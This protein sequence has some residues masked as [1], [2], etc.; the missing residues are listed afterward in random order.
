ML[1]NHK[2]LLKR[3]TSSGFALLAGLLSVGAQEPVKK[4]KVVIVT[5]FEQGEDT[6]D[7]PGEFQLWAERYPL[8]EVI[9][10]PHGNRDMRW[11]EEDGVLGIVTGIGTAKAAASITAVALDPRFDFSEAYWLLAGIAGFDP[12]D[13]S[14]ASVC[15][16]DWVVDGDLSHAID[17]REAPEDW[18]TG[19]FP[20]RAKEPYGQPRPAS[21]GSVFHLNENLTDWAYGLTKDIEL[22]DTEGLQKRRS[23]HTDYPTAMKPPFVV[24]GS[25]LAAMNYWHGAL[26][27]E[28]A[29]EWV[30]YWTDGEGE[31]VAS[32]MEGSG[33]MI[34]MEFLNQ[35]GIVDRDRVMMLRSASNYTMQWP[36]ATAI[37]S[38]R[39]E[40]I[41]SYSA[42]VPALESAYAIGSPVVREIVKNWERYETTLPGS[43][44]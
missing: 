43:E 17:I 24:K 30:K 42:F 36:G 33:M 37:Q 3:F 27:N 23:L 38:K 25:Y 28:W 14:L 13:A 41:G 6:G 9:P 16:V 11:N 18:P 29:N 40:S 39:G 10:L 32:A 8:P 26:L 34:A 35:S 22:T 31:F 15:W 44:E 1:K 20:F 21:E 12:A 4:V 7:K 19:R 2:T 5:L